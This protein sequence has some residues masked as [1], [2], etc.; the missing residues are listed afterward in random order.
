M[1]RTA[2]FLASTL[3]LAACS[4][5]PGTGNWTS[6][7]ENGAGIAAL[8]LSYDGRALFTTEVPKASWHCFWSAEGARDA[9]LDCTPSSHPD[10]EVRYHFRVRK[11]GEGELLRGEQVL[12]RF[13]RTGGKPEIS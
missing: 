13:R 11:N 7:G 10:Q 6:T 1:K 12:G 8:T 4:P 9:V 3:L 2:L 5:H